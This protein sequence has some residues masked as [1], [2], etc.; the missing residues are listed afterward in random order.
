MGIGSADLADSSS[1]LI[2]K[3]STL[4]DGSPRKPSVRP[5]MFC[6]TRL[7]TSAAGRF[8]AAATR[9]TCMYAFAGEMPG[10]RPEPDAVTASGGI[11]ETGTWSNAAICCC[12]CWISLTW[13]GLVGPKLLAE[14]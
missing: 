8:L 14:E 9:S 11:C 5:V 10:S 13:A 3:V 4:T 7:R 6:V 1:S 2:F 12:R